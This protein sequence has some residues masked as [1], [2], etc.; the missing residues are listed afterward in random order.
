MCNTNSKKDVITFTLKPDDMVECSGGRNCCG[1]RW[2]HP[3]CVG[4]TYEDL[5]DDDWWCSP[6][7]KKYSICCRCH[8]KVRNPRRIGCSSGSNCINEEW[9]HLK[10]VGL[11]RLPSK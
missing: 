5:V 11:T 3:P 7:C 4:A 1:G 2:F 9:F 8:T 6:R 10:C